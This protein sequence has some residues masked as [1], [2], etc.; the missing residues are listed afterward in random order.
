MLEEEP[1][2]LAF[3]Q[4]QLANLPNEDLL[5]ERQ[6]LKTQNYVLVGF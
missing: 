5:G 3:L 6:E 1:D 4:D 2:P